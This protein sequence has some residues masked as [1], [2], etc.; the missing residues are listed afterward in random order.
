MDNCLDHA[1]DEVCTMSILGLSITDTKPVIIGAGFWIRAPARIL[2]TAYGSLMGFFAGAF[3]AIVLLILQH[4]SIV[5]R[6]WLMRVSRGK[7]LLWLASLVGSICYHTLCEGWCGASLGKLV[8]GLRVL[9][10]DC[11]PCGLKQAL[12]RSLGYFFDAL[13]FGVVG[14]FEMTKTLMEQRHGDHW[15]KT[16]VVHSSQVP[17]ASKRPGLWFFLAIALGSAAW[18]FFLAVAYV[19]LG[20]AD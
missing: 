9:S 19:G 17:G 4:L 7:W 20:L 11:S 2:D 10:E 12:I 16:I 18:G 6:G 15:A 5:E 13:V 14:Y 8:C 3:G 1:N